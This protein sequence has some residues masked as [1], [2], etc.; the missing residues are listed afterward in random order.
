MLAELLGA[1]RCVG[2]GAPGDFLCYEC[3]KQA[4]PANRVQ[5]RGADSAT[6]LWA[7]AGAPRTLVLGLK[8]RGQRSFAVPLG[9]AVAHA[10]W[11]GGTMAEVVTWV[12][13]RS[14]DIRRRGFD[15]AELIA[16]QAA[17]ELGFEARPLLRRSG[18]Q[19]DQV[20]LSRSERLRNQSSQL[21]VAQPAGSVLLVDDLIT[22]GATAAS[23]CAALE[24]AGA[25]RIEVIAPCRA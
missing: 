6:A 10:A 16:R 9:R 20:G 21:L 22:T 12:P 13:G 7:W 25:Q 5:V 17:S 15:H 11:R 19:R 2:C 4:P 18:D 24:A 14:R 8:L 23:C 1:A 3:R